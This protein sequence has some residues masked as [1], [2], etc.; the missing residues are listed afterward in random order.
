[1]Q[2]SHYKTERLAINGHKKQVILAPDSHPHGEHERSEFLE[3]FVALLEGGCSVEPW[4]SKIESSNPI[5]TP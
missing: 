1:M 2:I 4:I 5:M 3:T